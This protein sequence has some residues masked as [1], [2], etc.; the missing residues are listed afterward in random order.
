VIKVWKLKKNNLS[1]IFCW[2]RERKPQEAKSKLSAR[3]VLDNGQ[4]VAPDV[5]V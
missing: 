1:A 5:K 3:R 2:T 4:R